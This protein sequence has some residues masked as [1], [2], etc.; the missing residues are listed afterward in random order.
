M[1][2]NFLLVS[3]TITVIETPGHTND[4]VTYLI[5]DAAFIGDTMFH[6]EVG[7]ARCDFPGGDA[8]MLYSSIQRILSSAG[9]YAPILMP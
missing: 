5:G 9:K 1:V 4:S 8:S 3:L 2:S 6:P 7:T